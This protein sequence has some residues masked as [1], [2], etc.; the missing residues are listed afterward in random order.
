MILDKFNSAVKNNKWVV[1]AAL[2]ENNSTETT[3]GKCVLWAKSRPVVNTTLY[4]PLLFHFTPGDYTFQSA[5]SSVTKSSSITLECPP[6]TEKNRSST[7][8]VNAKV[9][10]FFARTVSEMVFEELI[11]KIHLGAH[12]LYL[13]V[14]FIFFTRPNRFS[15][16][17]CLSS[18][19]MNL[20]P[21]SQLCQ[22]P[23][24]FSQKHIT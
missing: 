10:I 22:P 21:S 1:E 12:F 15:W 6:E 5:F 8:K 19:S 3:P 20:L 9:L 11:I 7:K 16:P 13:F 2:S 17:K 14:F 4:L 23:Y 18:L 24:S